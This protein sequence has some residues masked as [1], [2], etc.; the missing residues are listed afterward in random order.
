MRGFF[1]FIFLAFALLILASKSV[2]KAKEDELLVVYRLD[3][4]LDVYG[5]GL[6]IVMPFYRN[7]FRQRFF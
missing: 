1:F 4:L 2:V 7:Q 6:S 3:K 5:P